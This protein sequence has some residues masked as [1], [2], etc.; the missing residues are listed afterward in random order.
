MATGTAAFSGKSR[1]IT[2]CASSD[3]FV[4]R[5]NENGIRHRISGFSRDQNRWK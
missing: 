2:T 3:Q 4:S 1:A 5:L